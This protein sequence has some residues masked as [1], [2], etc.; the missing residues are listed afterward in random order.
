MGRSRRGE[1]QILMD[2]L[3]L[4]LREVKATHLMYK[5][6]LSYSTLRKYMSVALKQGLIRKVCSDDGSVAY[7]I[8]DKGKLFLEKLKDVMYVLNY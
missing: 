4:S 7:I 6:N 3:T 1:L 8:T 5:A 2:I